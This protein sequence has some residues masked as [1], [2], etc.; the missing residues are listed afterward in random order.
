MASKSMAVKAAKNP[1]KF[2]TLYEQIEAL[3]RFEYL[4][5]A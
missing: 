3:S 4:K 5:P 2:E 1:D